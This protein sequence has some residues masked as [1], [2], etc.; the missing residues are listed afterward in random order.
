[1]P[2][3][4]EA[5]QG[6]VRSGHSRR[7]AA[8]VGAGYFET[9]AFRRRRCTRFLLQSEAELLKAFRPRD[10]KVFD[11]PQQVSYPLVVRDYH[12]WTDEYGARAYVVFMDPVSNRPLGIVFRRDGGENGPGR[13][14]EWCHS[15]GSSQEIGLL[16]AERNSKTQVG[17]SLCR[18]LSCRQKIQQAADLAGRDPRPMLERMSERMLRFTREALG[19]E[20]V[21]A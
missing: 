4:G 14:C 20:K 5:Q 1:M 2:H 13:L 18:D 17:I 19:I 15:Y 10:K 6:C 11:L 16:M 21:P 3:R 12:S 7:D 9:A 8:A